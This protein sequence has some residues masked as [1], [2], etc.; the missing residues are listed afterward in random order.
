MG[1]QH[2]DASSFMVLIGRH[3]ANVCGGAVRKSTLCRDD[4]RRKVAMKS[5][6]QF[7]VDSLVASKYTTSSP[8]SY[9]HAYTK[10]H[11]ADAM[12]LLN[13]LIDRSSVKKCKVH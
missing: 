7:N 4:R 1:P 5:F 6:E 9:S 12:D 13:L 8:L 10:R 3:I 2:T 11:V